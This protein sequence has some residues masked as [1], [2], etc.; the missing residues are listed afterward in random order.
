[1]TEPVAAKP[2]KDYGRAGRNVPVSIATAIVLLVAAAL[3]LVFVK[4]IMLLLV[5]VVVVAAVWELRRG[6][7]TQDIDLPEQPLVVGGIVMIGCAYFWGAPA[8]VTAT[9]VTA[10]TVML[11]LLHRG[12]DGYVRTATASV[13]TVL[14]VPFLGSFLALMLAEG[15]DRVRYSGLHDAGFRGVLTWILVTVASD[16]GGFVAGVLFGRHPMAPVISP[17][18]SWEGFAGS[19]LATVG[20][21]IALVVWF[22]HG[23]WYVGVALG[24][25]AVVM[26]VLGDLVESVIKRDLGVK[27][28]SQLIPGHGGVMD[29]LDSLLATIA[30]VWLLLHYAVFT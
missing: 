7:L 5:A 18:K 20:A 13:F 27:D 17:K 28:M 11:W 12:V 16:I 24:V 29:R 2:P 21:G 14:Y 25:I 30:P 1:M 3:S 8:L 22:L 6:L 10:L 19:A 9:A 23:H 4:A 26:A 15:G